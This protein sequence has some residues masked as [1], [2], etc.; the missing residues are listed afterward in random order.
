MSGKDSPQNVIKKFQNRQKMMPYVLGGLA[1]A[2]VIGGIFIIITV[3]GGNN[4]PFSGLFS[5]KT[6]TVTVTATPTATQPSPTPSMTPTETLTPTPE[7]SPTPDKPFQYVVKEDDN[8]WLIAF[9]NNADLLYL[10]QI[11]LF[12]DP[13]NTCPISP[14]DTIWVP[15]PGQKI[16]TPT[17]VPD[18]VARGT[19]YDYIIQSGDTLASIASYF[20]STVEDILNY[21]RNIADENSIDVGDR[22]VVRANL[23]T[24]TPTLRAT[25]TLA[26]QTPGLPSP[27]VTATP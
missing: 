25:S 2:L 15:A 21:N 26:N 9:N 3:L 4:K 10:Q 8:C 11:N 1:G 13:L 6:P 23:I 24:P 12:T 27:S 22:I 5:T 17:R 20:N 18:D 7:A 16:P 19:R 14:G